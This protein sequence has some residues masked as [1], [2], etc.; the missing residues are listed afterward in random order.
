MYYNSGFE[1]NDCIAKGACSISPNISSMQEV[2]YILLRQTAYYLTRL[3]KLGI[4]Q[5][6]IIKALISEIALIDAAKD[7]SEAQILD[8]FSEKSGILGFGSRRSMC[9]PL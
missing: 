5:A 6:E 2:M 7:L 1:Y 9:F 3:E 8:S 4:R